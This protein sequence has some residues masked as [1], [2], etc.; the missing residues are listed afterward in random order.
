MEENDALITKK[1]KNGEEERG[2]I[3][4]KRKE[5][6]TYQYLKRIKPYIRNSDIVL[7]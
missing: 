2:R 7:C 4:K 3:K 6:T 1:T 5:K